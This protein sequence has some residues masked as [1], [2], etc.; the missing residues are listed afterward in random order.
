MTLLSEEVSNFFLSHTRAV[1][2]QYATYGGISPSRTLSETSTAQFDFAAP[3]RYSYE[4]IHIVAS[5]GKARWA[6][7]SSRHHIKHS[8]KGSGLMW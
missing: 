4:K 6:D 7:L 3:Y 2:F 1:G 5:L 8:S